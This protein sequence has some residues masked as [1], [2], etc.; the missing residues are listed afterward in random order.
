MCEDVAPCCMRQRL[1]TLQRYKYRVRWTLGAVDAKACASAS[2]VVGVWG[3]NL[4]D[5]LVSLGPEFLSSE[6]HLQ[7][8]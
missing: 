8:H 5:L 7:I 1:Q 3:S 2:S 6:Q 4:R